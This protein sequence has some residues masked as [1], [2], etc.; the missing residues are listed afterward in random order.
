ML[1]N[2]QLDVSWLKGLS[3]KVTNF[4]GLFNFEW[5]RQN[6]VLN[7]AILVLWRDR[8]KLYGATCW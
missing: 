8:E 3:L 2:L 7:I 6:K 5:H 4:I 1:V